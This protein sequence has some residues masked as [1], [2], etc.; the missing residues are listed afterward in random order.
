MARETDVWDEL[1][2]ALAACLR[3]LDEDDLLIISHKFSGAF[4][5]FAAQGAWGMRVEAVSNAFLSHRDQLSGAAKEG[6]SGL[7]WSNPTYVLAEPTEGSCNFYID[8]IRRCHFSM[9]PL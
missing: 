9:S 7:G 3:E 2:D 5:Q 4:I 1:R 6:L 8:V